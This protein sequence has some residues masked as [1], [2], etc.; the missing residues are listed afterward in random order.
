M[1]AKSYKAPLR[2]TPNNTLDYDSTIKNVLNKAEGRWPFLLEKLGINTS[3]LT[4]KHGPCPAC[5]GKDRFRFD[6]KDGRGTFYCNHCGSGDGFKLLQLY[7]GWSFPDT[8]N[9]VAEVLGHK[10]TYY[11]KP[12]YISHDVNKIPQPNVLTNDEICKR[13]KHLSSTWQTGRVISQNDP[14][15][16]YLRNRGIILMDY[17]S[18][19]RFHPRLPCYDENKNL[20]G[21]FPAM[22]GLVQKHDSRSVTIHRTY[23]ENGYKANLPKPKKLMMPIRPGATKGAAI[24]LFQPIDGRLVLAEGIET[25]LAVYIATQIPVWATISAGGM[26]NIKL[27]DS[28]SK[29]IIAADHDET[30]RGQKAAFILSQRLLREG[31]SVKRV[32]PPKIG[33]DFADMLVE[34]YR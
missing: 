11:D 28:V 14:V 15:D 32:M 19:L 1:L 2:T 13:K 20:L 16:C 30:G 25:A 17:P 29:V 10:S 18:V 12:K 23:L 33:Y 7:H 6:N 24:K 31:R 34:G 5:G 27:P 26:E 22:L 4:N 8:L 21:Y 9:H 3:Y